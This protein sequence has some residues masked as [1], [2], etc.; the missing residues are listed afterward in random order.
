MMFSF[1]RLL[2]PVF[3]KFVVTYKNIITT[4]HS[5]EKKNGKKFELHTFLL[6]VS[7]QKIEHKKILN[8]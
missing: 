1:H 2:T 7:T 5:I 6:S 4:N 8:L 3:V